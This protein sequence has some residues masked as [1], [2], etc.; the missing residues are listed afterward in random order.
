MNAV[1]SE[2]ET[3]LL[4]SGATPPASGGNRWT[5]PVCLHRTL[6]VDVEREVYTCF[7]RGC[8]FFGNLETLKRKLA[9]R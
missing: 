2:F 4:K 1:S 7:R 6:V 9:E 3:L 8:R 5:C